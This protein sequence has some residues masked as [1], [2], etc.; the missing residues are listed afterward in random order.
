M[1]L[2]L[3]SAHCV[4]P[5]VAQGKILLAAPGQTPELVTLGLL[6]PLPRT[7]TVP[8]VPAKSMAT[9]AERVT[10]PRASV[11]WSPAVAPLLIATLPLAAKVVAPLVSA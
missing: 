2:E 10:A 8:P 5:T 1:L 9:P 6:A 3:S 7:P 11:V 4:P